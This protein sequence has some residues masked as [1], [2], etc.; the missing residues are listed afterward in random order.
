MGGKECHHPFFIFT[1]MFQKSLLVVV[2]LSGTGLQWMVHYLIKKNYC[3]CTYS[4]EWVMK[5]C[6]YLYRIVWSNG[7]TA[8]VVI[9]CFGNFTFCYFA[10]F[11]SGL[12]YWLIIFDFFDLSKVYFELTEAYGKLIDGLHFKKPKY[13][14]HLMLIRFILTHFKLRSCSL[15]ISCIYIYDL[16]ILE[17]AAHVNLMQVCVWK[18]QK[19]RLQLT[20]FV[21]LLFA[22]LF[23]CLNFEFKKNSFKSFLRW[24]IRTFSASH[25][26]APPYICFFLLYW[27]VTKLR[28]VCLK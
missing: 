1:G 9:D 21:Y 24:N 7:N 4:R 25:H 17:V 14:G 27:H 19:V 8:S 6:L 12:W 23:I 15:L 11:D 10:C 13:S 28:I 16:V 26:H 5:V 2:L 20:V 18:F 3:S 22:V